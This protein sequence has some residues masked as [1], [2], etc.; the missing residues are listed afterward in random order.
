MANQFLLLESELAE[1]QFKL[2]LFLLWLVV[3]VGFMIFSI[4]NS[5]KHIIHIPF[6]IYILDIV[7]CSVV[8]YLAHLNY[9][10]LSWLKNTKS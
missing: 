1:Q 7:V 10:R 3:Q 4:F 8:V 6:Y 2:S 9:R 5:F